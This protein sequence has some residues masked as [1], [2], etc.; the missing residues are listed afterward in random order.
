M[1]DVEEC[2]VGQALA[3]ARE[4]IH[5]VG[6][7]DG[8]ELLQEPLSRVYHVCIMCVSCV[9]GVCIMPC[10]SRGYHV[11]INSRVYHVCMMPYNSYVYHAI[12]LLN[13]PL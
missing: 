13:E 8:I 2:C 1:E 6:H 3:L 12:Q 9:Y 10:N 11:S 7:G 4:P 5:A